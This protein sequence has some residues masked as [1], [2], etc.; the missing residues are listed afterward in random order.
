MF[1]EFLN[2]HSYYQLNIKIFHEWLCSIHFQK[3]FSMRRCELY[4]E[5]FGWFVQLNNHKQRKNNLNL[6]RCFSTPKI[7]PWPNRMQ[8]GLA[9]NHQ[10]KTLFNR[11]KTKPY[12]SIP[13][14]SGS[15]YGDNDDQ[16]LENNW[17]E[18]WKYRRKYFIVISGSNYNMTGRIDK[19][20]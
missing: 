19:Q 10:R 18:I 5:V 9:K 12:L 13:T 7:W 2:F 8:Y 4:G 15:D 17:E 1:T 6:L 14:L 16:S 11:E 3:T 20:I